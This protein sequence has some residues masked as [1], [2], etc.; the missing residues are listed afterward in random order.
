MTIAKA[1]SKIKTPK[2]SMKDFLKL[3]GLT[4]EYVEECIE[5]S[6]K[7]EFKD[8]NE[9]YSGYYEYY[10]NGVIV[11]DHMLR[12]SYDKRKLIGIRNHR[13]LEG[14]RKL[15][16]DI[17]RKVFKMQCD[18]GSYD[19]GDPIGGIYSADWVIDR[20]FEYKNG[21]G[22][23]PVPYFSSDEKMIPLLLKKLPKVSVSY[24][25]NIFTVSLGDRVKKKTSL[26]AALCLL[27]K[28]HYSL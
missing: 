2:I 16:I 5:D 4:L 13:Y 27:I 9:Y 10:K 23:G 24:S 21:F 7:E 28:D 14:Y 17:F 8:W 1:L 22:S 6:Y 25:K 3:S 26:S 11:K 15:D 12:S 19:T 18:W 20:D